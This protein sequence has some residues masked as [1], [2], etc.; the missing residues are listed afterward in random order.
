M[1][2]AGCG[3]RHF[4]GVWPRRKVR[5]P[6]GELIHRTMARIDHSCST[7]TLAQGDTRSAPGLFIGVSLTVRNS[8]T[9]LSEPIWLSG[10]RAR[11]RRRNRAF[12]VVEPT[13]SYGIGNTNTW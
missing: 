4:L 2:I 1:R 11:G 10:F 8:R 9:E 6:E 12:G 3:G 7:D 13:P 5:T